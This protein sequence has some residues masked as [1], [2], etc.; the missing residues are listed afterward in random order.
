[1][2]KKRAKTNTRKKQEKG[3]SIK[4]IHFADFANKRKYA[5]NISA[6]D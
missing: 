1:M 6:F 3:T 2:F 4:V 5:K